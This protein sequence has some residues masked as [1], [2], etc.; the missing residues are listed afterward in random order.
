VDSR[1][2]ATSKENSHACVCT[3]VM[4]ADFPEKLN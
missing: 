2:V 3:P 1:P 4:I